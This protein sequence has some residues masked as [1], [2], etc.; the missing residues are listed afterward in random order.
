VATHVGGHEQTLQLRL[1]LT[2]IVSDA[3]VITGVR[4]WLAP[5][6]LL[7]T[8]TVQIR[9]ARHTHQPDTHPVTTSIVSDARVITG[10]RGGGV[11]MRMPLLSDCPPPRI[12]LIILIIS[13]P[14]LHIVSDAH[15]I[16]GVCAY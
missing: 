3:R 7:H 9:S 15:V 10:V 16:T 12:L 6:I 13:Q 4:V 14:Y 8:H 5:D 11:M 1:V 2:P